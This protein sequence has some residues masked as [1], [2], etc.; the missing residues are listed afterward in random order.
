MYTYSTH[1]QHRADQPF[2]LCS[3]GTILSK[4]V[5]SQNESLQKS[6]ISGLLRGE[7]KAKILSEKG[8]SVELFRDLDASDE[9]EKIAGG[10][11]SAQPHQHPCLERI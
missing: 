9:I 1:A 10:Y 5:N 11:D 3:G 2:H 4:L 8:I 6:S 7:A